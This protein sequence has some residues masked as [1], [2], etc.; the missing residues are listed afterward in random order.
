MEAQLTVAQLLALHPWP[1]AYAA[2]KRIEHLWVFELPG[3]AVALWPH[4]ADTSRMNRALGT[5]EMTF[6]EVA[7]ERH[8]EAKPGGV[9]HAWVEQPWDWVANQWLTCTRIYT[10]GFMTV[11][12]AIHHL[13]P[14]SVGTRVYVY[15]GA[16]PRGMFGS[17]ALRL[18]FP[19]LEKAYR[20]VLPALAAQLDRLRPDV[21]LAPP[22]LL[23]DDAQVRLR[24][25]RAALKALT[26]DPTAIDTLLDWIATGDDPDLHRIQI[27]ERARVWKLDEQE[28][29]RVALHATRAGLLTLSWDTVCPHCRG[30]RDANASLSSLQAAAT[31]GPCQVTF[32]TDT[33]ETVEITFRV[34]PSIR[35]VADQVYCSAEPAKKEHIRVQRTLA[36]GEAITLA[37]GLPPGR[38]TVWGGRRGGWYLDVHD[39]GPDVVTWQALPQGTI[40]EGSPRAR[41]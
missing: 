12:Y 34:H 2:H 29:L 19:T 17:A 30:V 10:R 8:G 33:P 9:R 23:T 36:P 32:S 27:R 26:L 14:C 18:G 25:A 16:I 11:M 4:I 39:H 35:D 22:P 40:V 13:E 5:A 3:D 6:T 24:Q 15:F 21:L 41:V 7:G 28:L 31:C 38:Y 1:S 37:P 20:R